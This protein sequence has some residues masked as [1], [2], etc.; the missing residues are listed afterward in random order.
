MPSPPFLRVEN[1]QIH[2]RL[3]SGDLFTAVTLDRLEL[4]AGA[5]LA[6][7][8]PSG[9]GKSSLLA[10]LAGLDRPATGRVIWGEIDLATLS[11]RARDR[12][13]HDRVGLVF[14][15]FHL[16][17]GLDV[18]GNVLLPARFGGRGASA[19]KPRA[20]DL[21]ARVGLT[22][23]HQPVERLSRGEMQRV[24]VAR[25]LLLSPGILLADEPTASLDAENS[26]AIGDLL[27]EVAREQASTL[28]VVTHDAAL[29]ARLG[30][31]IALDAGGIVA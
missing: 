27:I 18:L 24:A 25:A 13:R 10:A 8:G 30:R 31:T 2:H 22:R 12:W 26:A 29:R 1:L 19:L 15:D 5:H 3:P 7:T 9:S 4:A 20:L 11:E 16:F 23:P 6:L 14:Q 17:D 21:I 28:V